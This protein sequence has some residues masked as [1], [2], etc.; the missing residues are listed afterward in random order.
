MA[1]T[2]L[3]PFR[4]LTA[5]VALAVTKQDALP[6]GVT[7]TDRAGFQQVF[8]VAGG[9]YDE[10]LNLLRGDTFYLFMFQGPTVLGAVTFTGNT[11]ITPSVR[12]IIWHNSA[13]QETAD[14]G[15][16]SR[17]R[18]QLAFTQMNGNIGPTSSTHTAII[19]GFWVTGDLIFT[20]EGS[21]TAEIH[22]SHVRVVGDV[23]G[24]ADT[25][26][27]RNVYIN[28]CYVEGTFTLI[29]AQFNRILRTEF[30]G[31]VNI[32]SYSQIVGCEFAGT[33]QMGDSTQ[34]N[35][36]LSPQGVYSSDLVGAVTAPGGTLFVDSST[37]FKGVG[38]GGG[39][40]L[41]VMV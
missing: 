2:Q 27:I 38:V 7:P 1:G 5:A 15:G 40:T 11:P 8:I 29:Q 13:S 24:T 23:D 25:E 6:V 30:R 33:V 20:S 21:T 17:R 3:Q 39:I 18:P 37:N 22:L 9:Q 4:T 14:S 12:N 35:G 28:D 36:N 41:T 26:G 10:D 16:A 32:H 31:N 19:S 34:P